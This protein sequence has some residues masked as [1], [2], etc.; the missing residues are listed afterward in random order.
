VKSIE[1][2]NLTNGYSATVFETQKS[3]FTTDLINLKKGENQVQIEFHLTDG[4]TSKK[5][6]SYSLN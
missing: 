6:I 2:E 5:T 4:T 3:H 1:V